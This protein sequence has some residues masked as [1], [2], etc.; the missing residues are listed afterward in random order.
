M[1]VEGTSF[2]FRS[3]SWKLHARL[4]VCVWNEGLPEYTTP[5]A[6]LNGDEISL[7]PGH[8]SSSSIFYFFGIYPS[9]AREQ[10]SE[11]TELLSTIITV[12]ASRQSLEIG[13]SPQKPVVAQ[14]CQ[15][16]LDN[17][18]NA[19][20]ATIALLVFTTVAVSKLLELAL[21]TL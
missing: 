1:T 19:R 10:K 18:D 6:R 16:H 13:A 20:P 5:R 9:R 3:I 4:F 11:I 8:I 15:Q 17:M 2:H 21:R 14:G 12:S 7:V